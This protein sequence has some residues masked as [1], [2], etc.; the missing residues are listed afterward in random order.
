MGG[1]HI[2]L[3][4]LWE[5]ILSRCCR[6]VLEPGVQV[7]VKGSYNTQNQFAANIIKFNASACITLSTFKRASLL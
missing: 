2:P 1:Q 6:I 4:V 5:E 3:G 7:G